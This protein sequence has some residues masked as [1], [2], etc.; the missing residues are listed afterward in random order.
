MNRKRKLSPVF[1]VNHVKVDTKQ[2]GESRKK[3]MHPD[4]TRSEQGGESEESGFMGSKKGGK[5]PLCPSV[6]KLG[7]MGAGDIGVAS[8]ADLE[9]RPGLQLTKVV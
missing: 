6:R 2:R 5:D 4:K 8:G 1:G 7:R 9:L 3:Q